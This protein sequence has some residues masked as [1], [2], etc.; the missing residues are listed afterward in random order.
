[1]SKDEIVS[2]EE[3]VQSEEIQNENSSEEKQVDFSKMSMREIIDYCTKSEVHLAKFSELFCKNINDDIQKFYEENNHPTE[4]FVHVMFNEDNEEFQF[5][6][7]FDENSHSNT[8]CI[9]LT[10]DTAE[11]NNEVKINT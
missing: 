1:M 9:K 3:N 8:M 10:V 2:Q 6:I 5:L 11:V 7:D 4:M